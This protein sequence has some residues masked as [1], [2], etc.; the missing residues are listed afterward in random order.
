MKIAAV[1][2]IQN[3]WMFL[4]LLDPHLFSP[5]LGRKTKWP[6]TLAKTKKVK[7]EL[8]KAEKVVKLLG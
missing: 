5:D 8:A 7:R 6:N 3:S 4:I 2:K 1:T